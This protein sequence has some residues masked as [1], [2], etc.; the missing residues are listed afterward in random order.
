MCNGTLLVDT[1]TVE[2]VRWHNKA[3]DRPT[4]TNMY[5]LSLQRDDV[6]LV[7]QSADG[8]RY[9]DYLQKYCGS[10]QGRGVVEAARL[11]VDPMYIQ[12]LGT[13]VHPLSQCHT[14]DYNTFIRYMNHKRLAA[15]DYDLIGN[16]TFE[17]WS[18]RMT[19]ETKASSNSTPIID[20]ETIE[21]L[22]QQRNKEALAEKLVNIALNQHSFKHWVE[23]VESLHIV[24]VLTDVVEKTTQDVPLPTIDTL[25]GPPLEKVE[26]VDNVVSM[27]KVR[28]ERA[29]GM[30]KLIQGFSKIDFSNFT[31]E[32]EE[33]ARMFIMQLHKALG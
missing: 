33:G 10:D 29:V 25:V 15:F 30:E 6:T 20:F 13:F 32:Q 1:D 14:A 27:K 31:P 17:E 26:V 9:M 16:Q 5:R 7:I 23:N 3:E 8:W 4:C 28:D 12:D 11:S 18:R 2:Y 24:P 21:Y 19:H 22:T